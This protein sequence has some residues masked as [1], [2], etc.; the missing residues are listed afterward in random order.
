MNDSDPDLPVETDNNFADNENMRSEGDSEAVRSSP[1]TENVPEPE[2]S[3]QEKEWLCI[4]CKANA[5]PYFSYCGR[6]FKVS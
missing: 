3:K 4:Q 5:M 2:T 1:K 6:C